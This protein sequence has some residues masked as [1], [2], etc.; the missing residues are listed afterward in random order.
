[1][2]KGDYELRFFPH[3]G[4]TR[5]ARYGPHPENGLR[6]QADD[7]SWL[8]GSPDIKEETAPMNPLHR[9]PNGSHIDLTEIGPICPTM[10]RSMRAE[11][12]APSVR[13]QCG[14]DIFWCNF[15]N[16]A[17]AQAYADGLAGLVNE[18][19]AVASPAKVHFDEV[20]RAFNVHAVYMAEIWP[21]SVSDPD[22]WKAKVDWKRRS[23]KR[24]CDMWRLP[25]DWETPPE[26][27]FG[28]PDPTQ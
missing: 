18:A 20:Y 6:W 4:G 11:D 2:E 28:D 26:T 3:D 16:L 9:L 5:R 23:F 21:E 7:G 17:D 24:L 25:I 27:G 22:G 14:A 8:I 13:I 15:P 10:R 12:D 1:M 19:R